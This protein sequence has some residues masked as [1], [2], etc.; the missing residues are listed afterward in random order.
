MKHTNVLRNTK[1]FTLVELA[2]VLVIIGLIIGG[3]LKGRELITNS[4]AKSAANQ[5]TSVSSADET[6]KDKYKTLAFTDYSISNL[7]S[8]GILTGS[9]GMK[10]KYGGDVL[11]VKSLSSGGKSYSGVVSSKLPGDIALMIDEQLDDGK[12]LS[13][14]VLIIK[15]DSITNAASVTTALLATNKLDDEAAVT[16][17]GETTVAV[18]YLY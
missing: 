9:S 14:S 1:G 17:L 3:V 2:I 10:N 4:K 5:L 6:F 18:V 7:Q 16:A 13:G 12:P 15:K 8:A 11:L